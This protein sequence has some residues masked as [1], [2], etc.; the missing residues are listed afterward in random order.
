MKPYYQDTAVTIYHGDCV[1]ILPALGRFDL[2][3]T[4]P[5]YGID[6]AANKRANRQHGK[7]A[8]PSRDYGCSDWDKSTPSPEI[9]NMAIA[10]ARN[11]II[12]GGNYFV[13]PPSRGWLVWDKDNGDN[14]YADCELAWSNLGTAVRRKRFRWMGMLQEKAGKE[15][16]PRFH[17]TQKPVDV[18]TWAISVA[19]DCCKTIVDPFA[20]SGT[21]GRAAK[22]MRRTATLIEREERYCEIAAMRMAQET[23]SLGD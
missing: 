19:G 3:L 7:A 15:K 13:L 20:G 11:A 6:A 14:G 18:M 22:D 9:I 4:D 12:W 23:L 5:P 10:S 1:E 2:L 8:A 17:P 21:T 16:E